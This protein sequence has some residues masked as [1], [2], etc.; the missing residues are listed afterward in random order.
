MKLNNLLLKK[1][2]LFIN[3]EE[4]ENTFIKES[5]VS[6]LFKLSSIGK[7]KD[8]EK[9]LEMAMA[10]VKVSLV[11]SENE[12]VLTDKDELSQEYVMQLCN[13]VMKVNTP[14]EGK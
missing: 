3:G 14:K 1:H 8:K 13:E 4:V 11:N 9:Q 7:E 12:L 5:S 6:Q 10:L 2:P